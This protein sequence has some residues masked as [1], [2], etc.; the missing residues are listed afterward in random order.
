MSDLILVVDD[1]E[2]IRNLLTFNLQREGYQT[3][4]ADDGAIALEL[5]RSHHPSLILL[6]I[7]LP[8]VDGLAVCREL[9]K[10]R[11][12]DSIPIIMLTARGD[13][14]DRIVGFELGA[15]DYVVKPFNTRELLLRV[16]AM[17][18][19]RGQSENEDPLL[20]CH[21]VCLDPQAH[22]V[23]INDKP[24]ELTALQFC[25]LKDLMSNP[26]CVRSREELLSSVWDYQFEG[27]DRTVDTH[28][29]RLRARLGD[30]ADI[31]ETVRGIG[32]RCKG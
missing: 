16:K 25:L 21:S 10:D 3:I 29:K 1:D 30:A 28:I 27:Y 23:T 17:L 14:V 12:T 13:E 19:R 31:I 20:R 8:R 11:N 4:E 15:D 22:K 7:M 5:V 26:G 9:G 6:D 18:R 24:V 2:D 32:Y